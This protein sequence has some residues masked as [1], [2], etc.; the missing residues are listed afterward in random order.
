MSVMRKLGIGVAACLGAG[1]AFAAYT[2]K[3]DPE[4]K[5]RVDHT[6]Q[7]AQMVLL[8]RAQDAQERAIYEEQQAQEELEKA[9]SWAM[10]EWDKITKTT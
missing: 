5:K 7:T 9:Q 6:I 3:K 4:L 2:I 8:K 10:S 1:V